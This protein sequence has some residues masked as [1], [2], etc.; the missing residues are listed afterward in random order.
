MWTTFRTLALS[1]FVLM[2]WPVGAFGA[3]QNSKIGSHVDGQGLQ[4]VLYTVAPGHAVFERWGHNV[5]C[6]RDARIEDCYDFGVF[7]ESPG[8]IAFGSLRGEPK[9]RPLRLSY[10]KAVESYK[11]Q[12]RVIWKQTLPLSPSQTTYL[13]K[14]L[15]KQ[16]EEQQSYAYHP[17]TE[18]CSTKI[19]DL[20]DEA[21]GGRLR[22]GELA[23]TETTFLEIARGALSGRVP[24]LI[25]VDLLV[26]SPADRAASGWE[27]GAFPLTLRDLMQR[28]LGA[29][30][31]EV[32]VPQAS[33]LRTS[34]AAG[35]FVLGL[36]AVGLTLLI[37]FRRRKQRFEEGAL[38][39]TLIALTVVIGSAAALVLFG[40]A[41]S[42]YPELRLN[43][44]L[45]A[46]PITDVCLPF[47]RVEALRKYLKVR[48]AVATLL[49]LLSLSPLTGPPLIAAGLLSLPL[50]A[51][52]YRMDRSSA[53]A[54]HLQRS[55]RERAPT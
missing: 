10:K 44:N 52:L 36:I 48:L 49:V 17:L 28:R 40:A 26:G 53:Q 43:W 41:Y 25:A 2:A 29:E 37:L 15:R 18:N 14:E 42:V 1:V 54:Q 38:R 27:L 12:G 21:T 8:E 39:G 5:L 51:L 30:P 47:L 9:F 6:V 55:L 7:E 11:Y 20:V 50:G 46:L 45:L 24:E 23:P 35:R 22:D 19:R 33:F 31:E 13:V 32:Y 4:V 34:S 3:G 16:V